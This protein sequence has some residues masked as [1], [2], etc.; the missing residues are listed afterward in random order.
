MSISSDSTFANGF[1]HAKLTE[2]SA[3]EFPTFSTLKQLHKEI[4]ANA[5]SVPSILGGGFHGHLALVISPAAYLVLAGVAFIAPIAPGAQAIYAPAATQAQISA[6]NRLY[7]QSII[8]YSDY[9]KTTRHLKQ[10]ILDAVPDIYTDELADESFGYANV[11][12]LELLT[13]L[14][15]TYGIIT[16]DD[17][18]KNT[19][20]LNRQWN[21]DSPIED[22]W[23]QTRICREL[24]AQA[25]DPIS[26]PTAVRAILTNLE[27]S[28]VFAHAVRTWR[29]KP[30]AQ[31]TLANIK[32]H[33]N[34]A[35]KERIRLLSTS[36]AGY[37]TA[38]LAQ[39][40]VPTPPTLQTP[41]TLFYCWSHGLGP[42]GRHTSSTCRAKSANHQDTATA[43]NMLGGCNIIHRKRDEIPVWQA[44]ARA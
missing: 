30:A 40:P 11:T 23:K 42:N 38:A 15:A 34:T 44:P 1:P 25:L 18:D 13:H 37:H 24:A 6:A 32:L 43:E 16:A 36:D 31:Q 14:D 39:Q 17:L 26:E 35:N 8:T 29:E 21:P 7:D 22:V 9:S 10:Q 4:N 33:F 27:N 2:V 20:D 19:K 41:K 3:D 28:G 12:A 5:I